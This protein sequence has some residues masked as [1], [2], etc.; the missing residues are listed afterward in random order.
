MF[1]EVRQGDI[2]TITPLRS[3]PATTTMPFTTH[4]VSTREDSQREDR[5]LITDI[6][7][8]TDGSDLDG[9]AGAAAVLVCFDGVHDL[10]RTL[11][12]R[13]G[14]LT[15]HTVYEAESVRTI[16][17]ARLL[18]TEAIDAAKAASI[19]LDNQPVIRV[20]EQP[21]R[22]QPGHYFLDEFRK[23]AKDVVLVRLHRSC[24]Y[25]GYRDTTTQS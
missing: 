8:Y 17:G 9:Q 16:L 15:G 14:P 6:R 4:I 20:S 11:R 21:Y 12:Y 2:E 24:T 23:M 10:R 19:S 5:K 22:A 13:L 25:N 1:P 3:N 18:A 7:V